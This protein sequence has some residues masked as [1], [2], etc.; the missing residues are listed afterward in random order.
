MK[1][2]HIES[3][4]SK[5]PYPESE[6]W[7][8][9]RE[10]IKRAIEGN[11]WPP[12]SDKF[13]IHA[14]SGKKSGEGNGVKP[15]KAMTLD[16]MT[17]GKMDSY[18]A[19][20]KQGKLPTT[21]SWVME[22]PFPPHHLPKPKVKRNKDDTKPEKVL[23]PGKSDLIYLN[24]EGLICFEWET[25][26]ISSSHRSLNK[27][28]QGLMLG[29]IQA[30][31]LVVPSRKMYQYLTDRVGNYEELAWY[32]P[33]WKSIKCDNGVLEVFVV[34]Q[35]ADDSKSSVKV[36]RIGKGTD[37]LAAQ[38]AARLAKKVKAMEKA[39]KD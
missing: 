38:G 20:R 3:L 13:T 16:A 26:N 23:K 6:E 19:L 25:G 2:V 18:S 22:V 14:Q 4:I 35:D 34:E 32:F 36:Q 5:G 27:L 17:G 37:G 24:G 12:G 7:R 1:I 21:P 9:Q 30:G 15:I 10:H 31:V 29:H 39:A 28:A 11:V 33:L 8:S